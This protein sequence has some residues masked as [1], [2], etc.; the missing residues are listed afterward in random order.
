M[1]DDLSSR[2]R[3]PR[4]LG[5]SVWEL[6]SRLHVRA[7]GKCPCYEHYTSSIRS[8]WVP[9]TG[10]LPTG[11]ASTQ[12][13]RRGFASTP[14]KTR[15]PNLL[16]RRSPSAVHS[17]PQPSTHA[18]TKGFRFHGCPQPST[19]VHSEWL[20]TWLPTHGLEDQFLE[21]LAAAFEEVRPTRK[22]PKADKRPSTG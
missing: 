14:G 16:I 12:G 22:L 7:K 17:R 8:R 9:R 4:N 1:A 11:A 15:T 10:Y 6:P 21:D 20:P 13:I 2:R 19:L 18:G 3:R 5:E